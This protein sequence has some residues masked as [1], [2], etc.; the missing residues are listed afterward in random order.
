M[1]NPCGAALRITGQRGESGTLHQRAHLVLDLRRV[2]VIA[3]RDRADAV[4]YPLGAGHQVD[5]RLAADQG[6]QRHS[7]RRGWASTGYLRNRINEKQTYIS[8]KAAVVRR[9]TL[10]LTA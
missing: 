10:R 7:A 3:E 6:F 2:D 4:A 5:V 9:L 1:M 8:P